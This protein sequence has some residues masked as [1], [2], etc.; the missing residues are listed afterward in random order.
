MP[1]CSKCGTSITAGNSFCSS[2]GTAIKLERVSQE[3]HFGNNPLLPIV[4][5]NKWY[6]LAFVLLLIIFLIVKI[7]LPANVDYDSNRVIEKVNRLIPPA[8][9]Q[10]TMWEA[11]NLGNGVWD[12]KRHFGASSDS[13]YF[14]EANETV[15]SH[16]IIPKIEEKTPDVAKYKATEVIEL[17][18]QSAVAVSLYSTA[19]RTKYFAYPLVRNIN[20]TN[21]Y[22]GNG[23]WY[24][25]VSASVWTERINGY[26]IVMHNWYFEEQT[27]QLTQLQ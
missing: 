20:W 25:Q 19:E 13:W 22:M 14:Y 10:V 7:V 8:P 4:Q 2:C 24:V 17:A 5:K 3:S 6:L 12:V 11:T 15:K 23:K 26:E 21:S 27:A 16:D 1:F 18:K 9:S